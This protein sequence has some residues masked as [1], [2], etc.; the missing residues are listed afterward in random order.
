MYY[1]CIMH[2][3]S[4]KYCIPQKDRK[5]V[6]SHLLGDDRIPGKSHQWGIASPLGSSPSGYFMALCNLGKGQGKAKTKLLYYTIFC[7]WITMNFTHILFLW[8][9]EIRITVDRWQTCHINHMAV[10]QNPG[11]PVVHIKIAGIYGC[12]SHYSNV[13]IGID[14]YPYSGFSHE[15]L[16]FSIVFCMFTRGYRL[17]V[18]PNWWCR[19]SSIWGPGTGLILWVQLKGM[20][21]MTDEGILKCGY[22]SS[23]ENEVNHI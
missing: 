2:C 22:N 23:T 1:V 15:K 21:V 8:A 5:I 17:S 11:T 13:S 12:S 4:I 19:I 9:S 3:V 10:C 7:R 18:I 20:T 16:W 6:N 14:P